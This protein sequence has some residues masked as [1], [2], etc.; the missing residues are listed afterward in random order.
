MILFIM[1]LSNKAK[2]KV[3]DGSFGRM[4]VYVGLKILMEQ[5]RR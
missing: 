1:K 5:R 4:K 2:K 3:N